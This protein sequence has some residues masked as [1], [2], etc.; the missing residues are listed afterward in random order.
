MATK[1][2]F[3]MPNASR[4]LLAL[5]GLVKFSVHNPLYTTAIRL[6]IPTD[7]ICLL[8]KSD[9]TINLSVALIILF[10][11]SSDAHIILVCRCETMGVFSLCLSFIAKPGRFSRIIKSKFFLFNLL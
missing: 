9:T 10:V 6:G 8:R 1:S 11:F 5:L 7:S 3:S 2:F 4:M